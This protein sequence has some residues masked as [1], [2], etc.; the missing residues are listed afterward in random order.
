MRKTDLQQATAEHLASL[1]YGRGTYAWKP[2]GWL[3][4]LVNASAPYKGDIF[5]ETH[6]QFHLPANR[7]KKAEV[8]DKLRAL[9]IRR[10]GAAR[11]AAPTVA[12]APQPQQVD[13]AF[14][15]HKAAIHDTKASPAAK[16]TRIAETRVALQEAQHKAKAPERKKI[17]KKRK[18]Y[19]DIPVSVGARP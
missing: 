6:E 5:G 18:G 8:M 19:R 14:A 9:E 7:L 13:L 4:V 15:E 17:A 3:V 11:V 2:N 16:A 1:G 12:P 10:C